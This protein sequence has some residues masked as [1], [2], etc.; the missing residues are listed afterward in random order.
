MVNEH[1]RTSRH[2][3]FGDPNSAV[4]IRMTRMAFFPGLIITLTT[5]ADF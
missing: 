3:L 2:W 5:P 4:R 1:E